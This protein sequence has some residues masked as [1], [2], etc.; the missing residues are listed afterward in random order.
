MSD[1]RSDQVQRDRIAALQRADRLGIEATGTGHIEVVPASELRIGDVFSTDGYTVTW[2]CLLS[3]GGPADEVSVVTALNS[4]EKTAYLAPDF[5]CPLWRTGESAWATDGAG[6]LVSVKSH[7]QP[8][9]VAALRAR[10]EA[11]GMSDPLNRLRAINAAKVAAGEAPITND[12][13][14]GEAV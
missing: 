7:G 12:R 14:T 13:G 8:L 4:H 2:A 6:D 1:K 3:G 10:R 9:S 11:R 5:P